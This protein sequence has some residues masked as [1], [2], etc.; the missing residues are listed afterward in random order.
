MGKS[1]HKR[2]VL[3]HTSPSGAHTSYH[4]AVLSKITLVPVEMEVEESDIRSFRPVSPVKLLSNI[5]GG[6]GVKDAIARSNDSA[7]LATHS[8]DLAPMPPP[9]GQLPRSNSAHSIHNNELGG[10]VTLVAPSVASGTEK[11]IDRLTLLEDTFTAYIVALRSRSGNVVGR[12][13][14]SRAGADEL[15]VNELYNILSKTAISF[16][17]SAT[18]TCR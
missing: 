10:K 12:V 17:W 18:L 8:K 11:V 7:F 3:E 14:R 5:F 4:K 16:S 15:A 9:M 1:F 6:N 2:Y 13:L